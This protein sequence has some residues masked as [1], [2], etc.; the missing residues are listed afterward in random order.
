MIKSNNN[1]TGRKK[2]K[3]IYSKHDNEA[4]F[5]NNPIS[6][7]EKESRISSPRKEGESNYDYSMRLID[8]NTPRI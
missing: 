3:A 5:I 7:E 6:E 2:M 1:Q 4:R 8:E